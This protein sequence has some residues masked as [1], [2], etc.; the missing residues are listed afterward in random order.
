[1][2]ALPYVDLDKLEGDFLFEK[3]GSYTLSAGGEGK[4]VERQ[5]HGL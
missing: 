5:D 2:F 4:A 1:M 3:N